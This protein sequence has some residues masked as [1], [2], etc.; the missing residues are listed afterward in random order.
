V[1]RDSERSVVT[2]LLVDDQINMR[3]S[4]GLVLRHDGLRVLEAANSSQALDVLRTSEVDVVVTDV[5]LEGDADGTELLRAI[6]SRGTDIE[7]ILATAFGTIDQAVD[8]IK[9][10]AYDY[11]TKP[12][13]PERLLITVRRASER[14]ALAREVRQL[15]AQVSGDEE[16]I[17]ISHAMQRVVQSAAQLAQSDSTVLITG[18]S[19]TGKEL[20][21]RA[22]HAQ[23]PRRDGKFVPV[24]CGALP[25]TILESEL[26]GHRKGAFTGATT[27][28]K[29]LLEEA[30]GGV[31]FLDEI[32]E[33]AASMQVRLLRFLQGG[34]VRRVGDTATRRVDVRLVAATH[35]SLEAEVARG[36]FRHDFYYRINV[37][38]IRIPPLRERPEDIPA[39]AE[40]F[41]KRFALRLRRSATVTG[42][43]PGAME[44]LTAYPWPGNVR[45]LANAI[46]RATNL[47][48]G[49]LITDAD[50]PASLTVLPSAETPVADE[51]ERLI[52]V[53][54]ETRWN[55]SRAAEQLGMSRTTLWRKMREHRI[56]S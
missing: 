46:E 29:G 42:F 23:G 39:L 5:R 24:N 52:A 43:S 44:L 33:M 7:V 40:H 11:L 49:P 16:I 50:L 53:L 9:A 26:F 15:R 6:K 35:R 21:A 41:L 14:R 32:G 54:Q 55:Q 27:D 47:A 1:I 45:E 36:T 20:V 51:R 2:V 18:E 34:E 37:I 31:L 4:M 22:L 30:H 19:G 17:A 8:A 38:G 28:R 13:D 25:E 56:E 3:R 12:V 48:S 10:G